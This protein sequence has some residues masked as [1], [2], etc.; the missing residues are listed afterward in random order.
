MLLQD[1][2]Y[3]TLVIDRLNPRRK[4]IV[5]FDSGTNYQ[6]IVAKCSTDNEAAAR[7]AAAKLSDAIEE[8]GVS[9]FIASLASSCSSTSKISLVV[10]AEVAKIPFELIN[11]VLS[12]PKDKEGIQKV[13][14]RPVLMKGEMVFQCEESIR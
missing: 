13:K 9:A 2:F 6:G 7:T 8:N 12:N 4:L 5:A 1:V 11:A 10:S 3:H 14:V